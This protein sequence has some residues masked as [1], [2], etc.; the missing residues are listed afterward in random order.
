MRILVYIGAYFYIIANMNTETEILNNVNKGKPTKQKTMP[1]HWWWECIWKFLFFPQTKQNI[2]VILIFGHSFLCVRLLALL[3]IFEYYAAIDKI[4]FARFFFMLFSSA[5]VANMWYCTRPS[6][7]NLRISVWVVHLFE[8]N[9]KKSI[10]TLCIVWGRWK[11]NVY[12]EHRYIYC[13]FE[14]ALSE[15]N[16][17]TT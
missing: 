10:D 1:S 11:Q 14:Y 7:S 8:S 15:S 12:R 3:C 5:V 16:T 17:C 6:L 2:F 4:T 9:K 13:I